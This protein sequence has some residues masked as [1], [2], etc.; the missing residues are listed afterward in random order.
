MKYPEF[1]DSKKYLENEEKLGHNTLEP[2]NKLE[3]FMGDHKIKIR[4]L[5]DDI[6]KKEKQYMVMGHQQKVIFFYNIAA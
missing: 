1:K 6:K 3:N 4:K 5:F 2:L